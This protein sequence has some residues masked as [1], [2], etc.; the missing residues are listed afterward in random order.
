M[1]I[2]RCILGIERGDCH[3]WRWVPVRAQTPRW[4]QSMALEVVLV[5]RR[6]LVR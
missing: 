5:G 2:L 4:C 3:D 6:I 1:L